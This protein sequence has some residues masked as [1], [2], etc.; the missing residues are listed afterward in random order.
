MGWTEKKGGKWY[1]AGKTNPPDDPPAVPPEEAVVP[2]DSNG[3]GPVVEFAVMFVA[4]VVGV[5]EWGES[6]GGE[7]AIAVDMDVAVVVLVLIPDISLEER[8]GFGEDVIE[9]YE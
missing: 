4:A 7:V 8:N 3:V 9:S 5:D 2:E 1:V 6:G